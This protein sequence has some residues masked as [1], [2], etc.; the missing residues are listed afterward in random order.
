MKKYVCL[1]II[2]LCTHFAF[3]QVN[4]GKVIYKVNPPQQLNDYIDTSKTKVNQHV[5]SYFVRR[6]QNIKKATP[7]LI[8]NLSFNPNESFFS[9]ANGMGNDN[10][11]NIERIARATGARGNYYNNKKEN[12]SLHQFQSSI[13]GKLIRV[14]ADFNNLDWKIK[15][16][17][18][19]IS[20][21]QC[22]KAIATIY[23][24]PDKNI[25]KAVTAWFAPELPFQF[26][27]L[28]HAG[29]PGLILGLELKHFYFYAD[30]IELSKKAMKIQRPSKG[31][32]IT[33]EAFDKR[34]D[35][36]SKM[37]MQR[38]EDTKN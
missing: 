7:Y 20:G 32:L 24:D 30:K 13:F 36:Y 1:L 28:G 18:K 38:Y 2:L 27:P 12:L 19:M 9:K 21:Y 8:F 14:S 23:D 29:L 16:E 11:M 37:M 6:Y 33:Q 22:R 34:S 5:N 4:S 25:K 31:K 26:G 15:K 35:K 3:S 17:T 10:G